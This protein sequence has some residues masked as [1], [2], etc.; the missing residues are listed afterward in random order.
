[1]KKY[2][3]LL[4]FLLFAVALPAQQSVPVVIP[5]QMQPV[6]IV[7]NGLDGTG[8]TWTATGGTSIIITITGCTVAPQP[9][10]VSSVTVQGP[11]NVTAGTTGTY[12]ATVQ[13]TNS[14]SQSVTWT[15]TGGSITA[16][17]VFTP[18]TGAKTGV[19]TATSV[20]DT[21]K[22]GT[23]NVT[24]TPTSAASPDG[25]TCVIAGTGCPVNDSSG[26]SF[27]FGAVDTTS[28]RGNVVLKNGT[29]LTTSAGVDAGKKLLWCVGVMYNQTNSGSWWKYDGVHFG[30]SVPAPPTTCGSTPVAHNVKINWTASVSPS[31]SGYKV[32]RWVPPAGVPAVIAQPASTAISFEDDAVTPGSTYCYTLTAIGLL[33]PYADAESV[34]SNSQQVTIPTP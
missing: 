24:V 14:P 17:G 5:Q 23:F 11:S 25:S 2:T 8:C 1:M 22:N 34:Q 16:L 9:P 6:P 20:V 30:T 21:T 26:N 13:G 4:L 27:S 12:T 18:A 15:A 32:Y 19:V 7:I 31:L 28:T 33:P 29:P 10:T 3:A